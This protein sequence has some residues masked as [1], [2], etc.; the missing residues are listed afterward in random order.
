MQDF[1]IILTREQIQNRVKDIA[2]QIDNDFR[3]KK[4]YAF[5][6]SR[7]SF[8]F[9][10]DLF[11]EMK[12]DIYVD[13]SFK[14]DDINTDSFNFEDI[15]SFSPFGKSILIVEN[16]IYEGNNIFELK[17]IIENCVA[18]EVKTCVFID[19]RTS[20]Q[21]KD[22][23]LKFDYVGFSSRDIKLVG[24]GIDIKQRYGNLPF[25]VESDI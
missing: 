14:L 12:S 13:F 23:K 2:K 18:T 8:I 5:V 6:F 21:K 17:N 20:E 15:L 16:L 9:A 10:S 7:K 4:I 22:D 25:F 11:R 19:S 24:Y 3:D 1:N